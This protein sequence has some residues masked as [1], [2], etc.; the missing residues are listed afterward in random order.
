MSSLATPASALQA[1]LADVLRRFELFCDLT[2]EEMEWFVEHASDETYEDG[3]QL[4]REGDEATTMNVVLEGQLR[5][6]SSVPGS[7]IMFA[8]TG[9]ATGLLPFSRLKNY[10]GTAFALTRLRLARIHRDLFPEM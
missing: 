3:T 7:P 2:D 1:P 5:F 9:L 8:R 10:S 4:V 6:Q